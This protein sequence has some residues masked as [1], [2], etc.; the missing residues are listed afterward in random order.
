MSGRAGLLA[1]LAGGAATV[2]RAWWVAR[3]DGVGF[4]FTDHDGDL[5]FAGRRFA[6]SSGLS[7]K[8]LQQTTG[9]S[10]DNTEAMGALSDAAID[11][12]DLAAGRFDGAEVTIWAVNWANPDQ[13]MV[14]FKG[15][16]GEVTRAG[17]AFKVDLRGQTEV[18][19]RAQ[20]RVYQRGCSAG[21]GDGDC[22]FDLTQAGFRADLVVASLGADGQMML[23]GDALQVAGFFQLGRAVMLT[24]QAAGLT[25]M[26]KQDD[27]AAGGRSVAL[28]QGFALPVAV[29]DVLRLEAGCDRSAATCKDKFANLANFQ[30]F[31]HIPGEDWQISYP[32]ALQPKDGGSLF[33]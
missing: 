7:A 30:G 25:A 26:V 6:A 8:A 17:G 29:G 21:L 28:W 33:K 31:P 1:H 15:H 12:G 18:L 5:E 23:Q 27:L 24:G 22:R 2:A 9:L 11:E 3:R 16:F 10:V 32:D 13:H 20:G 4:G 19:N 14:Q